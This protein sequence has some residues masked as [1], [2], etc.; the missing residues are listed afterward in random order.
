M[1]LDEILKKDSYLDIARLA[2]NEAAALIQKGALAEY[3]IDEKDTANFVTE[4][5]KAA[6]K[7]VRQKLAEF[8]PAIPVLGEEEGG[9]IENSRFFWVLDPLDGTTN[10]IK[11]IEYYSV[12][13]ALA[14]RDEK[15]AIARPVIGLV[16]N[17]VNNDLYWAQKGKGAF[18]RRPG[19]KD[20]ALRV[21]P[22][23]TL[24]ESVLITGFYYDRGE[25]MRQTLKQIET[26][27]EK[28]MICVRRF[29]SAALDLCQV[30]A[31]RC[32]GFWEHHLNPWDYAAGQLLVEEAGG[33]CTD[34]EGL[35]L[36]MQGTSM[37]AASPEIYAGMKAV[38]APKG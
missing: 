35:D 24:K 19:Q 7:A 18:L 32:E 23:K 13:L 17:A 29:G 36:N 15:T 31:G 3:R 37:L 21:S 2:C 25:K 33:L 20:Q 16:L 5:D 9:E 6:E 14:Y 12:S 10:F 28:G 1:T 38:L 30:A 8:D 11:G 27:F 22:A 26:Y 4:I 34:W